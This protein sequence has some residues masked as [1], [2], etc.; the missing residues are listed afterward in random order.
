VIEQTTERGVR[1]L[2]LRHGK[3][4]A[5]DTPF[6]EAL[7]DAFEAAAADAEV[8]AVV[9]TGTGR[10]FS[11]GVDLF[12]IV[13]EGADYTAPFVTALTRAF[14]AAYAFPKPAIA[15]INGHAIA[16]GCILACAC[17]TRVMAKATGKVGAPELL[18]GVGFPPIALEILR[19]R[20][21]PAVLH[22][23]T[24]S[25]ESLSPD[26]ALDAGLVDELVAP[27]D[28]M[29]RARALALEAAET[30]PEAWALLKHQL[31]GP[32]LDAAEND[33]EGLRRTWDIWTS[34]ATRERI[35][36]YLEKTLGK[37]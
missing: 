4:N 34:E 2:T 7:A 25:G 37:R 27:D 13:K 8:R 22:R 11:A 18:V 30:A 26:A 23:V 32:R 12:R 15:A 3:A 6:S 19:G 31:H 36:S 33:A 17:D 21:A 20:L 1:T 28:L 10:I 16:G 9:V 14:R 24:K 5:F 35:A 29:P